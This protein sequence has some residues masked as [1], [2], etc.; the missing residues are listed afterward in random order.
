VTE[1]TWWDAIKWCNLKSQIENR[2]PAYHGTR[3]FDGSSVFKS[4]FETPLVNWEA[5]GYRLPTEAEWEF[6]CREGRATGA[7]PWF[8]ELDEIGWYLSNSGGNTHPVGTRTGRNHRFE[9]VDIHG[10]VAEWCWDWHETLSREP[11]KDPTGAISGQFR[12]FRGG[13]WADPARNC[14]AAYRGTYSPIPPSSPLIG[15]R[16]VC[17]GDPLK[18][19]TD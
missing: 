8:A 4:G 12:V 14:R 19:S 6:A 16:P 11:A 1:I 18:K 7:R 13:S 2:G 5:V 9:L 15:F 17:G 3:N 10:N